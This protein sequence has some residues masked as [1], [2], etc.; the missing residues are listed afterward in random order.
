M[1]TLSL[2][3]ALSFV[4]VFIY[5][6]I[7]FYTL[8][9]NTKST[10]H[11]FFFLLCISYAIWSFAYAFAYVSDNKYI[12]SL[13][14]KVSAIGWCSF[15][16]LTLYLVLLITENKITEKRIIGF[17]I[18]SPAILFFY[19]AVFLFGEGIEPSLSIANIFY[20][21]NFLYNFSFLLLSIFIVFIWGSKNVSKRI[22]K[23]SMII[24]LS[25]I[26]PFCLNLLTQTILPL[27]GVKNIPLMGQL[28]SV[29]MILGT[30]IAITKY[31]FLRLPER[32]LYEE[33]E[34]KLM[35]MV[36][37]LNEKYEIVR[38]SK[39]TLEMLQYEDQE[40][41]NTNAGCLFHENKQLKFSV[42]TIQA[43]E[44]KYH[45]IEIVKKNGETIPTNITYLPI[46]DK[47]LHDFLGSVLIMQDIR[48]EYE[49]KRRNEQLQEK[50]IRD[51]LTKLY[52]HQYSVEIIKEEI[53]KL[54]T[55]K[56]NKEL[57][58]MMIDIDHFKHVNDSYGHLFG[59]H[60]LE[61]VSS[62]LENTVNDN[63]YV[64]RFGGEEF[65]IILPQIGLDE[66]YDLGEKIRSQIENYK[67]HRDL[68]LTVSIGIKQFVNESFV[69][70]VKNADDLLYKA[71]QNGRNRIESVC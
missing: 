25:S 50:T 36:L 44:K 52:N 41:L 62:I 59:D 55:N 37:F 34:N 38:I 3:S 2:F 63:G 24:V 28:Y 22:K 66:A 43:E 67:F 48:T 65:I 9:Q 17:L 68:N 60:V 71:K 57:S 51:G 31:K 54:H 7:G 39:H 47:K 46:F 64:G 42:D 5:L 19:M 70:F 8:K 14:N 45:D 32:F 58:L 1:D 53:D 23:Q 30:Y 29:I 18:F 33:I 40:L 27:F 10:V 12:F 4:S 69:Q 11:R 21:G 26:L 20:I 6:Y 16:A 61:T 15:S 56:N 13:W 49:L 35:D